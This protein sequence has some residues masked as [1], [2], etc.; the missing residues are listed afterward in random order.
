VQQQGVHGATPEGYLR[1]P[2]A[3]ISCPPPFDLAGGHSPH[4]H[5]PTPCKMMMHQKTSST[6]RPWLSQH[7]RLLLGMV[8]NPTTSASGLHA[9]AS[10]SSVPVPCCGTP[11]AAVM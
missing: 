5:S 8:V 1:Q 6:V 3:C 2:T 4:M 10:V 7:R 11:L 9:P